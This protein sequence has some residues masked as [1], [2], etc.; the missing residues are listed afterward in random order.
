MKNR[1]E[2]TETDPTCDDC[3]LRSQRT[4]ECPH[5]AGDRTGRMKCPEF[6]K[7]RESSQRFDFIEFLN[8]DKHEQQ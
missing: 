2:T 1:D 6:T 8:G 7:I 3:E 4:G 5:I